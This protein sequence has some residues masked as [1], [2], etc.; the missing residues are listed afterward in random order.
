MGVRST[1]TN[2]AE[3]VGP[4]RA[5]ASVRDSLREGPAREDPLF[6][7][8][9][10]ASIG[11]PML[12]RNVSGA[13]SYWLVPVVLG[14]R[15]V[16]FARV[17]PSGVVAA[18]GAFY[19]RVSEI[20]HCPLVVTRI[21]ADEAAR[22]AATR[23][24]AARDEEAAAP[25]YVHDGPPGREAWMVGVLRHGQF[26]RHVFVTPGSVYERPLADR[27]DSDRE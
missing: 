7:P 10:G 3:F 5:V 1:V 8:W 22:L 17:L 16:G 19:R 11:E 21:D 6:A 4:N 20:A 2:D 9:L 15:V 18:F 12:V 25:V 26:V 24:D 14:G 23:I 27:F 13:A